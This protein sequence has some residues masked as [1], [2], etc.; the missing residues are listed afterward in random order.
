MIDKVC[1]WCRGTGFIEL[2]G[3]LCHTCG[4]TGKV[5]FHTP[6]EVAEDLDKMLE[7]ESIFREGCVVLHRSMF[8]M[9]VPVWGTRFRPGEHP[10][11]GPRQDFRGWL[12]TPKGDREIWVGF[13][14]KGRVSFR[15]K[16]S[17][18]HLF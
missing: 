10:E 18:E 3:I 1:G 14:D 6:A 7:T 9:L 2:T 5:Q 8:E 11:V 17:K 12:S 15:Q 13:V 4:G 16:M